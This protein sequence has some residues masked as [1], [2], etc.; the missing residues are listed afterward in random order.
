MEQVAALLRSRYGLAVE[1]VEPAP[2]GWIGE[3]YA[4]TM[5]DGSRVFVKVYPKDRLPRTAAPAL[6]ALAELHRLGLTD[7]SRPIPSTSGAL[8]ERLGDDLLVVFAYLDAAPVAFTFGWDRP[9]DLIARVHQQ[10]ERVASPI[11]RETFESL[12]ADELW[13]TLARAR[14]EPGSD[15]PRL[16]L[17][18]FLEEQGTAIGDGWA[19]FS[20]IARS[21]RTASFELVLT[22]GDWPF[23]LLQTAD[24][25]L[26]LIDWD[27]LLLAP[28]ERDTWFADDD[29]AFSRGY[30][31]RRS[32]HA[33]NTLATAF[34]VHFRYFE[35]L[36][37]FAKTILGDGT[38]E[39]RD[40]A[41]ALLSGDWMTGLRSRMEQ[42]LP[43]SVRACLSRFPNRST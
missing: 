31:A 16:G 11:E 3:T 26:Y 39:R 42:V 34:Y 13:R 19:A 41:L 17:R 5:Q 12:D 15:A 10:T 38:L 23:N 29:P 20:E 24:G 30:R 43:R 21:C 32:G 1:R 35:E 4:V 14:E 18:C 36:L 27:E 25:T 37:D 6:P 40:T 22:H 28:A 2:R 7:V 8:H 33:E 9:G